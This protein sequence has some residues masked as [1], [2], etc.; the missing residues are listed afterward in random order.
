MAVQAIAADTIDDAALWRRVLDLRDRPG[1]VLPAAETL[2]PALAAFVDLY[3][4]LVRRAGEAFVVAH[5]AQSLDGR[6]ALPNGASQW[7]TGEEDLV[8]THRLR[9]L[10]DAV[11]VGAETVSRDDPQLT[12]RRCPGRH[13]VRVV[14]DPDLRLSPD[15]RV[16]VDPLAPTLVITGEATR[17]PARLGVAEILPLPRRDGRID[18]GA[19]TAA[20]AERGLTRLFIEGGGITVSHFVAAGLVDIL[21]LTVS[22]VILGSGRPSLALPEILDL[23]SGLRPATRRFA[24]GA[25]LLFE[26]RLR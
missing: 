16:L 3:R 12:V 15:R 19:I 17:L 26:C 6:I 22:P 21:H 5:L 11:L 14:I 18:P 24:L 4:P 2:P 20:L 1:P 23:A 8:H 13:P 9:A 7:L 10:A 25:D